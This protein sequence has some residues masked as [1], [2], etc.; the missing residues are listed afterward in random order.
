MADGGI[1]SV[2]FMKLLNS[3][4]FHA[5]SLMKNDSQ[6]IK[7]CI[8]CYKEINFELLVFV[9]SLWEG[10]VI[11]AAILRLWNGKIIFQ[12][13]RHTLEEVATQHP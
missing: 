5:L 10:K 6:I 7:M 9:T 4:F 3:R 2:Y 11:V 13:R 8:S 12:H 1:N